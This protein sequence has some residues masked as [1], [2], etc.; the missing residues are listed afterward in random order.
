M[1]GATLSAGGVGT[2]S[3]RRSVPGPTAGMTGPAPARGSVHAAPTGVGAVASVRPTARAS[4]RP[5]AG[6]AYVATAVLRPFTSPEGPTTSITGS[7]RGLQPGGA[8]RLLGA[9]VSAMIF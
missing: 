8:P 7:L 2:I 4:A 3:V 6:A 1:G 5:T 9:S